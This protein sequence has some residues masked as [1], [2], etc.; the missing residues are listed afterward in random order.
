MGW[1]SRAAG[2]AGMVLLTGGLALVWAVLPGLGSRPAEREAAPE[3]AR[4]LHTYI[5]RA[6]VPPAPERRHSRPAVPV[7][8][9]Y[10]VLVDTGVSVRL[11][12]EIVEVNRVRAATGI[13]EI[14]AVVVAFDGADAHHRG[15]RLLSEINS[16]AGMLGL[17][18]VELVDARSA[19]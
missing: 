7:R 1:L 6:S 10:L 16:V 3:Q 5:P 18:L 13:P 2:A 14:D 8:P 19:P 4:A 17:P 9:A 15:V 11:Q 12:R